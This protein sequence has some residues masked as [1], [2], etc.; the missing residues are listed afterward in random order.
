MM[1]NVEE[2]RCGNCKFW[3]SFREFYDD[4]EETIE[5]GFCKNAEVSGKDVN[6]RVDT[7]LAHEHLIDLD[8][9]QGESP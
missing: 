4:T 5:F 9:E 6:G 7:C 1:P 2:P 8:L 3:R